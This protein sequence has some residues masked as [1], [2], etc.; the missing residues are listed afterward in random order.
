MTAAQ[1]D[2]ARLFVNV[3]IRDAAQPVQPDGQIR[4]F[5]DVQTWVF[6]GGSPSASTSGNISVTP[7][8]S[9]GAPY[10][11]DAGGILAI[12][13]VQKEDA[14]SVAITQ[15]AGVTLVKLGEKVSTFGSPGGDTGPMRIALF[16]REVDGT[17]AS[18]TFN[19]GGNVMLCTPFF[20]GKPSAFDCT[21]DIDFA[22]GED[23][24]AG[25]AWS[26]ALS[27]DMDLAPLDQI[28]MVSAI[29]TDV[30]TP[31]Q[32]SAQALTATGLTFQNEE[33]FEWDTSTGNDAGGFVSRHAVL[34]GTDPAVATTYTATAGGT[35][36]N[37]YGPS[38]ALRARAVPV[39]GSL[40][41][42]TNVDGIVIQYKHS[43]GEWYPVEVPT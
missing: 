33:L 7:T 11:D 29:P 15:T 37:V 32:F 2:H 4:L 35:T 9:S 17:E 22:S 25:T 28:L 30:S 36:T 43:D 1:D 23:V 21:W 5:L 16:Y 12:A 41:E 26:V 8:G 6:L 10:P 3:G 13:V 39:A 40:I 31:N 34:T 14:D 42:I 20:L 27:P 19:G 18:F 24:V 38:V